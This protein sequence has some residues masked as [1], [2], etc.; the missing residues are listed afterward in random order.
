MLPTLAAR[1]E[2][3]PVLVREVC[4]ALVPALASGG[5]LVDATCG[6]GGHL[7]ALLEAA[8]PTRAFAFDR[9]AEARAIAQARL[10]DA[11]RDDQVTMIAG[12]FSTLAPRLEEHGVSR[13]AAVL[14]D[15]GVSSLQLDR[16]ERGFSFRVDAPL[17][18]R[19]DPSSGRSATEVLATIDASTLAR[20]LRDLGEEPDADR[21]ARAIVAARPTTTH[22]LAEIV[23]AAMSAPQR[24]K[25]GLRIHPATRTFQA[26]RLHVNDELGELDRLL[27]AAPALLDVGG[28]LAIISFHSLEDR[29]VKQRVAALTRPPH[30]PAHVPLRQ[31]ELP[32]P[33]FAVPEGFA[34]GVTAE[35]DEIAANPR[36]RSAR[37]RV[38]ERISP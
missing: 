27:A 19:M 14:A 8:R 37:L 12:P 4:R 16:G 2:H 38:V 34:R 29:R 17:D 13:V 24:R 30:V 21:I 31:H 20:I 22:A 10:V 35:P 36:S 18:M 23:A 9:D 32:R 28:R 25:L 26:L 11:A 1:S 5:V 7:V 15:L 6:L 33:R 3:V